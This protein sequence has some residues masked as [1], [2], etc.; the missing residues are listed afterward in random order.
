MV[1]TLPTLPPLYHTRC[2]SL[3]SQR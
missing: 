2:V 1:S 3:Y